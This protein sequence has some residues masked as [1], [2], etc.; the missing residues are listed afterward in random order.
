[1]HY[2]LTSLDYPA[3]PRFFKTKFNFNNPSHPPLVILMNNLKLFKIRTFNKMI[4]FVVLLI[5]RFVHFLRKTG[6][7]KNNYQKFLMVSNFYLKF[8][9]I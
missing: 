1:M 4:F 3:P 8:M 5:F 6:K 9:Y 2:S 7:D